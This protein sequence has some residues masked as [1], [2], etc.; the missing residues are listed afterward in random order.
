MNPDLEEDLWIRAM[1]LEREGR[2]EEALKLYLEICER[3]EDLV[4]SAISLL[5]AAKCA[6]KL[7]RT[8]EAMKLFGDAGKKYE[9]FAR[10]SEKTSP[11]IAKWAYGMASRCYQLAGDIN[12]FLSL[13]RKSGI[14]DEK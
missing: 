9:S 6:V 2:L 8:E 13:L 10:S 12:S 3:E 5:S 4:L 1:E 11:N 14:P 7:G